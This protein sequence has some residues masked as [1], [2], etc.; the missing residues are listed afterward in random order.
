M[1]VQRKFRAKYHTE[2]PTDKTIREW[3]KKFQQVAACAVLS[4]VRYYNVCGRNLITGLT[5]AE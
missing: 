2:L 4:I 3:Y 1:M 5:F